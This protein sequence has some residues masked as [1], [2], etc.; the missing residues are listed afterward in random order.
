MSG[1]L[2]QPAEKLLVA[3]TRE[4][5]PFGS[6]HQVRSETTGSDVRVVRCWGPGGIVSGKPRGYWGR[7]G[8]GLKAE[9]RWKA[10]G[11]PRK[12]FSE[13]LEWTGVGLCVDS[14]CRCV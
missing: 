5:G 4:G 11:E 1:E 8:A 9:L 6:H 14:G 3:H 13:V 2:G 10:P 7:P 12:L